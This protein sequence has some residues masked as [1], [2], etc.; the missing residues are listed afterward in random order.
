M[1]NGATST[2]NYNISFH[3]CTD[4]KKG[5]LWLEVVT[6]EKGKNRTTKDFEASKYKEA[7]DFYKRQEIELEEKYK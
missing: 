2:D 3:I 1:F 4:D 6:Y 7:L 5:L